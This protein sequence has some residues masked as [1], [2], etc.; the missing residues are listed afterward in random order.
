[1]PGGHPGELRQ[2]HTTYLDGAE[3][4]PKPASAGSQYAIQF[5]TWTTII[6]S[7]YTNTMYSGAPY[8]MEV[9]VNTGPVTSGVYQSYNL[10]S[11]IQGGTYY[12]VMWT[13]DQYPNWS[14][15]SNTT[16]T[17]ATMVNLS[18]TIPTTWF[19]YGTVN[20]GISTD[21]YKQ[22]VVTNSGNVYQTYSI[23]GS[24]STDF[25]LSSSP[26]IN[27]FEMEAAFNGPR[28]ASLASYDTNGNQLTLSSILCTGSMF[29]ID[30]SK[31][32]VG[33]DPF[34]VI[35]TDTQRNL[36]FKLSTPLSVKTTAQESVTVTI[37]AQQAY[38]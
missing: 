28:P 29:T 1:M 19:Y 17:W 5:A 12:I 16:S 35:S 10:T 26:G 36:W 27:T 18:I 30:G 37:T 21:T 13:A 22:A 23:Q 14:N 6:N 8:P 24:S 32:G 2:K 33:V 38:P 20:T 15:V 4:L 31:T 25:L 3:L 9:Y 7:T 34:P 11:L